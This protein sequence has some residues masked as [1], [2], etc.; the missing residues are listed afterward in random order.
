[1]NTVAAQRES[2]SQA[3]DPDWY[4]GMLADS[5][6]KVKGPRQMMTTRIEET[7]KLATWPVQN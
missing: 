4:F 5:G 7:S 6:N 3:R 1:M 2:Q